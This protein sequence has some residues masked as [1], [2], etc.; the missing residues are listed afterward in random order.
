MLLTEACDRS[1]PPIAD[2]HLE[3][4][5]LKAALRLW[6]T[7]G[8][9]GLTLR[10]VAEEANTTTPTLYK[11]F[12]NKEALRLALAYRFREEL[13]ADLLSSPTIEQGHRRYLA[14]VK[15]HP[16]EYELLSEYWGQFFSTPRPVRTWMLT[17]LA[18][19]LGGEPD[20][21]GAVYDGIFL[22]CHGAS[23]LLVSAPDDRVLEA[24]QEIC[25]KVCDKLIE[26]APLFRAKR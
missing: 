10:A 8:E 18:T 3:E 5:I 22:L 24:T 12:R 20:A 4:R 21:Y 25:V 9:S 1:M 11:R 6:R 2:K 23:T 16:R 26:N 14:Y 19:R 15:S 13:T 17:Q 7:R